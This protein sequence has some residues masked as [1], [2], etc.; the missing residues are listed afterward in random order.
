MPSWPTELTSTL[1]SEA[2]TLARD[3]GDERRRLGAVDPIRIVFGLAG[4]AGVGRSTLLEPVVRLPPA[5][6]PSAVLLAPVVMAS[7]AKLPTAVLAP[8]VLRTSA[9]RPSAELLDEVTLAPRALTPSAELL[10]PST[11]ASSAL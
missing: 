2:P 4:D 5:P 9:F 7:R 3:A 1:S 11:F 8:A 6:F 10:A